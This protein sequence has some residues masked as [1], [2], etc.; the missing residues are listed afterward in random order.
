MME[1]RLVK[2]GD[3]TLAGIVRAIAKHFADTNNDK[4]GGHE[5]RH[6]R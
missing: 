3:G 4:R 6:I 2:R 5:R 1:V